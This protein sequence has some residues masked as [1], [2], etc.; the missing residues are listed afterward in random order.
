MTSDD[1]P[2][3]LH[4]GEEP[5]TDERLLRSG[6]EDAVDD[7]GRRDD[8]QRDEPNPLAAGMGAAVQPPADLMKDGEGQW[9][10]SDDA[11]A[12]ALRRGDTPNQGD[13][14]GVYRSDAR[15][16]FERRGDLDD[17]DAGRA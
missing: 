2:V 5:K 4:G 15:G 16:D 10:G 6:P 7:Q 13:D 12:Q 9:G 14:G 1:R 8:V 11:Y 3:G 17:R